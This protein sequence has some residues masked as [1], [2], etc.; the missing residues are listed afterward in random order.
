MAGQVDDIADGRGIV[1][2]LEDGERVAVFRYGDRLSALANA[3]PTRTA[4]S[5]RGASWTAT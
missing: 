2:A 1:V 4:R 5:A 3:A